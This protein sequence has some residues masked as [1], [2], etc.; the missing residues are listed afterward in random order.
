MN[1]NSEKKYSLKQKI[2]NAIF[3]FV[4]FFA[5]LMY[6]AIMPSV[7]AINDLDEKIISAKIDMEKKYQLKNN[8][9]VL[10]KKISEIA[11]GVK[12]LDD[13]FINKNRELE[14]ITVLE[15][16]ANKNNVEQRINLS[17]PAKESSSKTSKNDVSVPGNISVPIAITLTGN[18]KN[19][20]NYISEINSLKYYI[21]ID[22]L[23][24]VSGSSNSSLPDDNSRR[25]KIITLSITAKTYWK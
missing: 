24:F 16:M 2:S 25:N 15:S 13:V 22:G 12:D 5:T 18:Y 21:N 10:N 14:F 3:L 23:D 19:I 9:L 17:S 8:T 20:I 11:S 6:F 7:A 4:G 1:L